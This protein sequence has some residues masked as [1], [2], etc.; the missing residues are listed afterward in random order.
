MFAKGA[1]VG[2][3]PPFLDPQ[4]RLHFSLEVLAGGDLFGYA[5]ESDAFSGGLVNGEED[6]AEG[7]GAEGGAGPVDGVEGGEGAVFVGFGGEDAVGAPALEE[8]AAVEGVV[9]TAVVVF[10]GGFALTVGVILLLFYERL[11]QRNWCW[12]GRGFIVKFLRCHS[13]GCWDFLSI[14]CLGS[15]V[16]I[17]STRF[18]VC[19]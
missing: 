12:N 3:P 9:V 2:M 11:D 14:L 10:C 17:V 19:N 16:V 4:Q 6:V 15:I 5:F 13:A 8:E 18:V 1:D 7:S